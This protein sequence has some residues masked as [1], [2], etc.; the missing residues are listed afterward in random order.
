MATETY[1]LR[2]EGLLQTEYNE[3]VMHFTSDNVTADDTE[4]NATSLLNSWKTSLQTLWLNMF[5]ADYQ[6]TRITTRRA[7]PKPS[8][9]AH[10]QY[11]FNANA[12]NDIGGSISQNLCPSVFLI[13][14]AGVKSGGKVFLPCIGATRVSSNLYTAAY[15]TII[16]AYF[17]AA[18]V[19]F[20]V[21]GVHWQMAI[22]SR[23]LTQ[24][25]NVM[26]FQ[27]SSRLGFQGK[28]RKPL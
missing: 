1:E 27:L 28:R 3:C 12:G 11:E 22:F 14:P 5:P 26:A 4:V 6:L 9:V 16:D 21:S 10:L 24:A 17:N 2:A 8:F 18:I 23:K 20:G 19:N 25:H 13:P 7:F 15:I